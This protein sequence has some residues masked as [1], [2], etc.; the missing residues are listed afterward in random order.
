MTRTS[1]LVHAMHAATVGGD[2]CARGG[3]VRAR[4]L[5]VHASNLSSVV[6]TRATSMA[7]PAP[8]DPATPRF[9]GQDPVE[10]C[11]WFCKLQDVEYSL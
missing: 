3:G 10:P 11:I 7:P 4:A 8:R 2:V 1:G 6:P 9:V 5:C